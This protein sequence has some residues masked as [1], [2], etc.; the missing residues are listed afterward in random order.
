M[1]VVVIIPAIPIPVRISGLCF[2]M[3]VRTDDKTFDMFDFFIISF[4][5]IS[6]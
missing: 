3:D 5:Q 1:T 6:H 4:L 2:A